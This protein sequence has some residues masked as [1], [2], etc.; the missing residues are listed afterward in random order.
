MGPHRLPVR[1]LLL[2]LLPLPPW[3]G[4]TEASV[5]PCDMGPHRLPV[6]VLLLTLLPLPPWAGHVFLSAPGGAGCSL[7]CLGYC[8]G[9][10]FGRALGSRLPWAAVPAVGTLG[11]YPMAAVSSR[12]RFCFESCGVHGGS[13]S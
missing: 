6:R 11:Y 5:R 3:A 4:P 13:W 7:S 9:G 10:L 8:D 1:V 12:R 2:T